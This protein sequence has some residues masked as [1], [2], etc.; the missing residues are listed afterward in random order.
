MRVPGAVPG[1]FPMTSRTF[2]AWVLVSTT[3]G[4]SAARLQAQCNPPVPPAA[5]VYTLTA[6][7]SPASPPA[8]PG[9][10]TCIEI[11]GDSAGAGDIDAFGF[12]VTIG[13]GPITALTLTP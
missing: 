13:G 5:G 3:S 10:T 1:S 4:L 8:C 12:N 2:A 7:Y 11:H 9:A 6:V